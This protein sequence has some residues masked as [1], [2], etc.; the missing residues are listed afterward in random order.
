MNTPDNMHA[1][2]MVVDNAGHNFPQEGDIMSCLT[3]HGI[4]E[5]VSFT[6]IAKFV[7]E[8]PFGKRVEVATGKPS[9]PPIPGKCESLIDFTTRG[10]PKA[11]AG[12]RVDHHEIQYV[13]TVG[14]NTPL[15]RRVPPVPGIDGRNV[16][17]VPIPAARVMPVHLPMGRG[18]CTSE[19]DPNVLVAEVDGSL[20]LS[21]EGL[22]EIRTEKVIEGDIDYTTG[23]ISFAGDLH[24]KGTV[25]GGF[26][27]AVKGDL[28]ID[29]N[30]EDAHISATG[31]IEIRGGASG[32]SRGLIRCGETLTIRHLERFTIETSDLIVAENAVNSSIRA[33]KTVSVKAVVGGTLIAGVSITA[34]ACGTEGET[35]TILQITGS[36]EL[37]ARKYAVLKETAR[38]ATALGTVKQ[39]LFDTVSKGMNAEGFLGLENCAQLQKLEEE[40]RLLQV[41]QFEREKEIEALETA[42][43]QFPQPFIKIKGVF[44][45]TIIKFEAVEKLFSAKEN[46]LFAHVVE[47]RIVFDKCV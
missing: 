22:F 13:I 37:V 40:K 24:I 28:L 7:A 29:G 2:V 46:N 30:V 3:A 32:S 10:K 36:G 4:I 25:R 21:K 20:S 18:T 12:G 31:N 42:L 47:S 15:V 41:G 43:A 35:K 44:P 26:E 39:A 23:N 33:R 16:F 19:T 14:K 45:G 17:G 1:F 5:G 11:V 34:Q 9:V 8:K 27:I 38:V 6:A